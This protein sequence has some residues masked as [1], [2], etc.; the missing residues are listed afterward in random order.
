MDELNSAPMPITSA[1]IRVRFS[2][3]G[4]HYWPDPPPGYA[5]LGQLHRHSFDFRVKMEEGGSRFMEINAMAS[6]L[7]HAMRRN[8]SPMLDFDDM[9]A[10]NFGPLSCE[11]L[12]QKLLEYLWD[13]FAPRS[14]SVL[15]LE[16]GL[17]GAGREYHL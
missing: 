6:I 9:G 2:V 8:F 13:Q 10:V 5:Y 11:D 7:E 1:F 4:Y 3:V 17:Q 15:V 12:A 14:A 16:D